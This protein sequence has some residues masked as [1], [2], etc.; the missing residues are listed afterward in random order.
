ML[1]KSGRVIDPSSDIDE[2]T[3]LL[4]V[5][6]KIA[7]V[8]L[9]DL[10]NPP[11]EVYNAEGM[12][13]T[14]GFID[15][16]CHLREPGEEYKETIETGTKSAAAGGFTTVCAM[17]NTNPPIDTRSIVDFV[18]NKALT[19]GVI[20]VLP[21]GCV[22]KKSHGRELS[23]M[24]ELA[25]AGVIGFSDDGKPVSDANIMRQALTYSASLGLPIINHCEVPELADGASMNEGWVATRLGLKGMPNTAEEAMVAR[26]ISLSEL[27]GGRIHLAHIST[28]GTLDMVRD[29]KERG[30]NV[31]CEVTPHHLTLTDEAVLSIGDGNTSF[32]AL[33][34]HAYNTT[35]KVNPPLRNITDMSVM[36]R[37]IKDGTIDFI[38]TDHAPHSSVDKVCT[39][40]EA[41]F[42]ISV[43]ET[44][45]GSVLS[46]YHNSKLDLTTIIKK[47]TSDPAEF[48][49][50]NLGTLKVGRPADVTVFDLDEDWKVDTSLFLSKG[51]NTPLDGATLTG[52][53][54]ATFYSG[55]NVYRSK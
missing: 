39:F 28:A 48:L 52:K 26:D 24:S 22:T 23:E 32:D 10:E 33:T 40:Q 18:K 4:I 19:E 16:H 47:L 50:S 41:A 20:R 53:V 34:P 13:V 51:K 37:G 3:D 15:I 17:P 29:A 11:S 9:L 55:E 14:P 38:A 31:T 30:I 12:I 5:D 36:A 25:D 6:G 46:L 27:T 1:I 54:K 35:A 43:L 8:G 49:G 42:G 44:A 21:I 2:I 45:L 7:K